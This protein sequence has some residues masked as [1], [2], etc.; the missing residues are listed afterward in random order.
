MEISDL[1][2]NTS[3][4]PDTQSRA[5]TESDDKIIVTSENAEPAAPNRTQESNDQADSHKTRHMIPR[6][7]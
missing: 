5:N 7:R 6:R 1:A 4:S 2:M 3:I